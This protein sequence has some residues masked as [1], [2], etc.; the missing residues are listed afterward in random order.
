M[1]LLL[2]L[3]GEI[4]E[5]EEKRKRRALIGEQSAATRSAYNL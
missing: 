4:L 2:S 3:K 5:K 1:T